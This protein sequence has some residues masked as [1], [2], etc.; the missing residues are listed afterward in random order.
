MLTCPIVRSLIF[1]LALLCGAGCVHSNTL[2]KSDYN[3]KVRAGVDFGMSKHAFVAVFPQAIDRGAKPY[4]T[5]TVEA[6]EVKIETY[7]PVGDPNRDPATG[8]QYLTR[9]FFFFNDQ[10]IEFGRPNE[11]PAHPEEMRALRKA[12]SN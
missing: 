10:L 1:G 4:P 7:L 8:M 6:L 2:S 3:R 5:G 11:W 12:L 9:W